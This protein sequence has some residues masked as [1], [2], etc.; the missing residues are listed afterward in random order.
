M[1]ARNGNLGLTWSLTFGRSDKVE[2]PKDGLGQ[3]HFRKRHAWLA[4]GC[5]QRLWMSI[6]G[7]SS[8]AP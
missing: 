3:W 5:G 6:A 7:G 1:V 2:I 4:S 8:D